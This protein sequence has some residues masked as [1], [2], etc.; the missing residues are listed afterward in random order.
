MAFPML[1]FDMTVLALDETIGRL[2]VLDA[3]SLFYSTVVV[4]CAEGS[5]D[6]RCSASA[7]Y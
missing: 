4:I 1:G 7:R 6:R 2:S 3:D 5:I